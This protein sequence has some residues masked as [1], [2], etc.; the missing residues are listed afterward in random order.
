MDEYSPLLCSPSCPLEPL[1]RP[2]DGAEEMEV[3]AA[4]DCYPDG[5]YYYV[6]AVDD[7]E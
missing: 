2:D 1:L 3:P 6:E 4:D 5:A 7:Q